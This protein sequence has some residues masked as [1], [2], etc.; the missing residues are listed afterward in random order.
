VISRRL[1]AALTAPVLVVA[2]L[3][4]CTE[5]PSI[6]SDGNNTGYAS[7]DGVYKEFKP[8]QR[9]APV[10]YSDMSDDG[11]KITSKEFLGKVHV[12]N[13]W[14]AGCGPCIAEAPRLESVYKHYKGQVPF[15]GVN[16]YDSAATANTFESTYKV[17]YPS[18]VDADT[19]NVQFA[20]SKSVPPDARPTT[21][22]IDR[23]GRVAA[24]VLG[25]VEDPSILI[26]LVDTV[27]AEGK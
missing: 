13:F 15:L 1:L 18:V 11:V 25:E 4:G 9:S 10:S 5:K 24:R 2:V 22:V 14:Y 17:T 27:V 7:G 6:A 20:F 16:T 26:S 19:V 3:A 8:S 21:L 12:L 23:E